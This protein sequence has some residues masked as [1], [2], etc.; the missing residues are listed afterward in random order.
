MMSPVA[1]LAF[2]ISVEC[3][4]TTAPF[5]RDAI[6]QAQHNALP[7]TVGAVA[8]QPRGEGGSKGIISFDFEEFV[9]WFLSNYEAPRISNF[10]QVCKGECDGTTHSSAERQCP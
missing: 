1:R 9:E 4:K 10:C 5:S 8:W 2:P 6:N 3:K 7:G